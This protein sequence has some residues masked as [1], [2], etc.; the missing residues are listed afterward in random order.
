MALMTSIS[1][2]LRAV[3]AGILASVL[4]MLAGTVL[5]TLRVLVVAPRTGEMVA[6][7]LELPF[8]LGAGWVAC[9]WAVRTCSL[10]AAT[11]LR[12]AMGAAALVVLL[13]LEVALATAAAGA[14]AA[15]IVARYHEPAAQLGLAAQGLYAAFPLLQAR[16]RRQPR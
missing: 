7:L 9:A 4:V 11:G 15:M 13:A 5:G 10:P 14:T 16:F 12:L 8:I 1:P 2:P 6:T 3:T